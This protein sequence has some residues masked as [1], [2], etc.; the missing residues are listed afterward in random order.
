MARS[1]FLVRGGRAVFASILL[2]SH[3]VTAETL[4]SRV[5]KGASIAEIRT[6]ITIRTENKLL[7][8]TR[9]EGDRRLT[10]VFRLGGTCLSVTREGK[11]GRATFRVEEGVVV[12]SGL[13]KGRALNKSFHLPGIPFFSGP[14]AAAS[15]AQR[16]DL[17]ELV[18][19]VIDPANYDKLLTM[20][21][22]RLGPE[23]VGGRTASTWEVRLAGAL[24]P[25]WHASFAVGPDGRILRFI[26]NEGPGTPD[27]VIEFERL[28]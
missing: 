1:S 7:V 23:L 12:S 20:R 26:G 15:F 6:E 5:T 27:V 24:A 18:F 14:D 19:A 25:F 3:V 9:V 17:G 4:V 11:E 13:W 8:E 28:E 16:S 2:F 10:T 21:L 22:V